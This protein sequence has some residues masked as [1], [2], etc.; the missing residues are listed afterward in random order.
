[1]RCVI[2]FRS[3][4]AS[5][6][7]GGLLLTSCNAAHQAASESSAPAVS[8]PTAAGNEALV[9]QNMAGA[10]AEA[11]MQ[12]DLPVAPAAATAPAPQLIQTA[13]LVLTVDSVKTSIASASAI[14][15]QQ[16]GD[17]LTLQDQTPQ[18]D[19]SRHTA[20]MQLRVPQSQLDATVA[21]LAKLGTVQRQSLTAEDVSNQLV[22][23]EARLRNLR[24]AEETVLQ[25]LD[26]SGNVDDVLK[27]TQELNTIRGSIEQ[28]DAQL[29]DLRNRVAY[30]TIHLRLEE[31]IAAVPPQRAVRDQLQETWAG[32]TRSL[33]KVTV[34]LMQLGIWLM[35][36]SPYLLLIAGAATLGYRRLKRTHASS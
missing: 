33:G 6:L 8:A 15:R 9:N 4:L 36:Y 35:V 3:T 32:A 19:S 23:Y 21:A 31:S 34:D 12:A 14:V 2:R 18:N 10:S 30:A 20:S 22:D 27:V 13:E 28:I 26:R 7:A 17:V 24:R 29:K 1:M 5:I 11:V 25:I 16:Q